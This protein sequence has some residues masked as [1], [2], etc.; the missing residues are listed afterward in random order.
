MGSLEH[1][2][3]ELLNF[4]TWKWKSSSMYLTFTEIYSFTVFYYQYEFYVV[5]GRTKN[6]I[7]SAVT[8]FNPVSEKWTE[9]GNLKSSRY[10]HTIDVSSDKLYVIGGS[11]TL[12]YCDLLNGFSCSVLTNARFEEKDYPQLYGFYP[13]T[14]E[15]GDL[16]RSS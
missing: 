10:G 7:L 6:K 16:N 12:E 11:E 15:L 3:T 14:C 4:S 2:K 5:G 1:A 9:I 13:S 8:S